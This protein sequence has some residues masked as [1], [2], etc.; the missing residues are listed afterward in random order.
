MTVYPVVRL[1]DGCSLTNFFEELPDLPDNTLVIL[2]CGALILVHL[3][4][5]AV[6]WQWVLDYV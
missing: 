6:E 3:D 2:T 1:I 5:R 4:M